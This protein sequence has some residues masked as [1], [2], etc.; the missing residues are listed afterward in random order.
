MKIP[1]E[2]KLY[3][4]CGRIQTLRNSIKENYGYQ[5]ESLKVVF[6]FSFTMTKKQVKQAVMS[7]V[8]LNKK[9]RVESVKRKC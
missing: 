9:Q 4:K 8:Y 2:K 5:F 1:A 6:Q 3:F 7:I